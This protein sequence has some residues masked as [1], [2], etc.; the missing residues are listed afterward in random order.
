MSSFT[1]STDFRLV[2]RRVP[3][4]FAQEARWRG[5]SDGWFAE[6]SGRTI[7]RAPFR[8]WCWRVSRRSSLHVRLIAGV[9]MPSGEISTLEA[10]QPA[11]RSFREGMKSKIASRSSGDRASKDIGM[12]LLFANTTD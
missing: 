10:S 3:R 12:T 11:S 1:N 6:L 5:R 2:I 9:R 7:D 4:L 8:A